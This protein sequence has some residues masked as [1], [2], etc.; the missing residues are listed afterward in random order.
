MDDL[1]RLTK[2]VWTFRVYDLGLSD[3]SA[4]DVILPGHP[5]G[6]GQAVSR[7]FDRLFGPDVSPS[8]PNHIERPVVDVNCDGLAG[9]GVN[10]DQGNDGA[11][12]NQA[13]DPDAERFH[14]IL[15][16]VVGT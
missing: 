8:G 6:E 4:F 2:P 13:I 9:F 15:H 11:K 5:E 3:E 10:T 14:E 12:V 1:Q 16:R 7:V